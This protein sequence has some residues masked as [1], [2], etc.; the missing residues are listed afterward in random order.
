MDLEQLLSVVE[1]AGRNSRRREVLSQMIDELAAE[2]TSNSRLPLG[3]RWSIGVSIAACIALFVTILVKVTFTSERVELLMAETDS[4]IIESVLIPET[5]KMSPFSSKDAKTLST[6]LTTSARSYILQKESV[7]VVDGKETVFDE[8]VNP[9]TI[10]S[11]RTEDLYA[12]AVSEKLRHD[13]TIE[14]GFAPSEV[15]NEGRSQWNTN[16][17]PMEENTKDKPAKSRRHWLQLRRAEPS[18]MDGTM[19]SFNLF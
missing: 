7:V 18:K 11:D 10:A 3:Y 16:P 8:V 19:L 6:E 1:K 5:E 9:V 4:E 2:E 12:D 13:E 17:S 15:A 14:D